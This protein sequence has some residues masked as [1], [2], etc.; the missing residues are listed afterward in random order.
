MYM[1]VV[2]AVRWK[3]NATVQDSI[4]FMV[5]PTGRLYDLTCR[6]V[7]SPFPKMTIYI[8]NS[9]FFRN[10]SIQIYGTYFLQVSKPKSYRDKASSV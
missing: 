1:V 7:Q 10:N 9:D 6:H 2:F 8:F 3:R 4:L 5:S